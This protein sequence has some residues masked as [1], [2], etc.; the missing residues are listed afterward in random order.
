[1]SQVLKDAASK[2]IILIQIVSDPKASY[3]IGGV[4]QR[5]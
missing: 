5:T 3:D 1:M 4:K 2:E